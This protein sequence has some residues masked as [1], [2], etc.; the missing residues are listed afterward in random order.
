METLEDFPKHPAIKESINMWTVEP[1]RKVF[2]KIMDEVLSDLLIPFE[3]EVNTA[4][5]S[6]F[7]HITNTHC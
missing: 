6:Y 7:F 4:F 5:S 2:N 1:K 3:V